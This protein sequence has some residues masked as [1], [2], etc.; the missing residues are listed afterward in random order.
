MERSDQV[1]STDPPALSSRAMPGNLHEREPTDCRV[2]P[3][4]AM[5]NI[6]L[7]ARLIRQ[8]E[9]RLVGFI[10]SRIGHAHPPG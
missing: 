10:W 7:L 5:T 4:I 3:L 1:A 8:M 2:A 9:L 6:V